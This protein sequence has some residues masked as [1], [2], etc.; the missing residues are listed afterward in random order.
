MENL[1]IDKEYLETFF[2]SVVAYFVLGTLFN[3]GLA[4]MLIIMAGALREL[5]RD[6]EK[7]DFRVGLFLVT[8]MPPIM[9]QSMG[10]LR[11]LLGLPLF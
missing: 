2:F 10:W 3:M 11:D 1:S 6:R 4:I 7:R 9:I 5:L 8:I